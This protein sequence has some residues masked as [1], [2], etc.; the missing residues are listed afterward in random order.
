MS[1]GKIQPI[2]QVRHQISKAEA[3]AVHNVHA[4]S[5]PRD[6]LP[7]F[8]TGVTRRYLQRLAGSGAGAVIL[9]RDG[10][11]IAGFLALR[12]GPVQMLP[13]LDIVGVTGFLIRTLRR[14]GLLIRLTAQLIWREEPPENCAEIDYFAVDAR[15]RGAGIGAQLLRHA[16]TEATQRGCTAI[17]TKTN[18]ADLYRHYREQKQAVLQSERSILNSTYY[19]VWWPIAPTPS[20][21]GPALTAPLAP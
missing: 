15:Y 1:E 20:Q 12:T 13:C 8:G 7:N 2:F 21:T 19:H 18:N 11:T 4:R 16:E 10:P 5:L 17:F 3:A 14:P 6:V 9:A